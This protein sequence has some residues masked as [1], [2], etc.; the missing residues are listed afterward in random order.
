M[1]QSQPSQWQGKTYW[2]IGASEGLGASLASKLS[3]QGAELILS[4]RSEDRLNTLAAD[5]PGP[6]RVLPLDVSDSGAVQKAAQEIGQIDGMIYLAGVYWPFGAKNWVPEQA[7]IMADVN[8]TGA[9]RAVGA[10]LPIMQQQGHGHIVLTG[11]LSAYGGL[12]GAAPYAA[13]K[14]GLMALAESLYC[15]LRKTPIKV[16]L[17]NPGYI[18]T[19]LTDKNDF[20]M[21]G[22]MSADRAAELFLDHMASGRFSCAFPTWFSLLFRGARLMP[23]WLYFRLFG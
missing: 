19:R 4:A 10:V 23:N 6:A 2:L 22:I 20:A 3:A 17:V 8:F 13:S 7:Q 14:A 9:I 11:S 16:Q 15:D 1:T 5:L 18:R 12:P 21:P